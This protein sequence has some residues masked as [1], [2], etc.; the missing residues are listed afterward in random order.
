M[1]RDVEL[2]PELP[3]L[4]PL[5]AKALLPTPSHPARVGEHTVM[6]T[7]VNQDAARFADYSRVCGFRLQDQVPA[8]WLHVLGFGL[9][10]HLLT[11]PDSTIRLP[12]VVHVSNQMRQHRPVAITEILNLAAAAQNLRP[13]RRGV[14]VDLRNQALV[15]DE[16]VWEGVSTYLAPGAKLSGD[17]GTEST[18]TD[19]PP[20]FTGR[21]PLGIWRLPA[22]L[23]KDYR[24]VS[25]DPNP[26]HTNPLA[27]RAFGFARPII[28][29]MWTHARLL[30]TL[31]TRL[32]LAYQAEVWFTRPILLPAKV[33]VSW[34]PTTSGW[35][36][37]VTTADGAKPY[38][39]GQFGV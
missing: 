29:G 27:A 37:A 25:G 38:L 18:Q 21:D 39:L 26:I 31:G 4:G 1:D 2:L 13:H 3:A 32:P 34:E 6:V 22:T 14:L 30:A 33:G 36:A 8:T 19:S 20:Q 12:G 35:D 9:Q 5:F 23:G 17:T 16:V 10:V 15:G 7:G 24:R 11:G 28:H